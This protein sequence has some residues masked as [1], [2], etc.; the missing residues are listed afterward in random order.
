MA[1]GSNNNNSRVQARNGRIVVH[2][3]HAESKTRDTLV[4]Q[5]ACGD[6]RA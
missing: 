1:S 2:L 5:S 4:K 6:N 3:L